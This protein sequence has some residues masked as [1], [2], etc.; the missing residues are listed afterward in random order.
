MGMTPSEIRNVAARA[1]SATMRSDG[2]SLRVRKIGAG[3]SRGFL[4][5]WNEEVGI[6]IADLALQYGG[7]ALGVPRRYPRTAWAAD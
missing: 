3:Q 4:H 2:L 5:E 6:E 1:W 7:E